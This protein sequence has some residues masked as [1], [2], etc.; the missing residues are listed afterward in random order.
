[1]E[2]ELEGSIYDLIGQKQEPEIS[3][4]VEES[5]K[6]RKIVE[7]PISQDATFIKG[8]TKSFYL[9]GLACSILKKG[10][11]RI[12]RSESAFVNNL[13]INYAHKFGQTQKPWK[14]ESHD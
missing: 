14:E 4:P 12:K 5:K 9:S 1:M 8:K 13:I 3:K 2:P 7:I 6:P 10:A 11:E